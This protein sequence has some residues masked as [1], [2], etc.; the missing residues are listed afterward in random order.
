MK[1]FIWIAPRLCWVALVV[2]LVVWTSSTNG[3]S[4]GGDPKLQKLLNLHYFFMTVAW[5]ASHRAQSTVTCVCSVIF[6]RGRVLGKERCWGR[7]DEYWRIERQSMM[8]SS[9]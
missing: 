5:Y 9:L 8:T 7:L 3:R 2:V 6:F 4:A 1:T